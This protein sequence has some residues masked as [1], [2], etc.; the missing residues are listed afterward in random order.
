MNKITLFTSKGSNVVVYIYDEV[1]NPKAVVHVVHGASEHLTRYEDFINYLNKN[2]YIALG[3][4]FLGHG[5]SSH[6]PENYIYFEEKEAFESLV[7]TKNYA[8]EH[9]SELPLYLIGHSM[10]SFLARK[11]LIDYPKS[12]A[13]A[14]ISGTTTMPGIITGSA[15]CLS[16][17]TRVFRGKK[18][19]SPLLNELGMG[20]LPKKMIKKGIL[21]P[22]EMWITHDKEIADYYKNSPICGEDFTVSAYQG[23]FSW[24]NY[25]GKK[26]KIK[27]GDE[28]TPILFIAGAEDPLSN[29]GKDIKTTV[30]LYKK[31]NYEF[32]ESIVY[33][34][35]RHEVLNEIDRQRVYNDCLNFFD[36]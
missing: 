36:K 31:C 30:D 5:E 10:G 32:I 6:A 16:A 1:N 34:N 35:M 25:V 14:I 27:K 8:E 24:I 33:D 9:Y 3:C 12:Y 23:M 4:D 15:K 17:I 28:T 19:I 21:Q 2:G 22:D 18:G 13:K 26:S 11:L 7:L 29:F 20:G